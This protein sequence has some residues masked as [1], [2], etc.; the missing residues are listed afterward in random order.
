[1]DLEAAAPTAGLKQ[2]MLAELRTFWIITL[3]LWVFL[4]TFTVYRRLILAETGVDYLHYGVALIEAL[5]IAKVILIGRL[6]GFSRRFEEKPLIVPVLYKTVLF[7]LLVSLF[8]VLE[9]LVDGWL[10]RQGLLGGLHDLT[11]IGAYELGAR[12][13]TIVVALVPLV[14]VGE[15]GRVLGADRLSA[16]FFS[17]REAPGDARPSLP[18]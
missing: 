13:L 15:I 7:G 16:M 11:D 18:R 12:T 4:G 5:V 2:R 3:Y 17:R 9:H 6:F 10:H 1:M 8:G 14:A